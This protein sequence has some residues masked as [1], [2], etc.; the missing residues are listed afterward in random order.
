MSHRFGPSLISGAHVF[1]NAGLGVLA[2]TIPSEG[3][4][5]PSYLYNDLS[6]PA[7]NGKEI[8]GRITRWPTSGTLFAYEDG[9]FEHLGPTDSFDYQLAVDGVDTGP[10]TTVSLVARGTPVTI[11]AALGTANA[12]GFAANVASAVIIQM[13]AGVASAF[14]NQAAITVNALLATNT[15]TA[16]AVG[17]AADVETA[18]IA[19][20]PCALGTAVAS[21]YSA[22]VQF[23]GGTTVIECS[24]GTASAIGFPSSIQV[25]YT[26][27]TN[28][29][30]ASA[31]GY[32]ASI[33]SSGSIVIECSVGSASASGFSASIYDVV[34]GISLTQADIDAIATAV[35]AHVSRSLSISPPTAGDVADAVWSKTLP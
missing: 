20:I 10:E 28:I 9:H 12:S 16:N 6:L 26:L 15:G 30:P 23:V 27:T 4:S 5:G 33:S 19:I 11:T 22:D 13:A 14:G 24:V 34:S 17:Y 32:Q 21:G 25:A 3:D 1:G 7:D 8:C 31:I 2:E 35:W 29:I 18:G